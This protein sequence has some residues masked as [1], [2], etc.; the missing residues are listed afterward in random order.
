MLFN[1][2]S[3][4]KRRLRWPTTAFLIHLNRCRSVN[5]VCLKYLHVGN[6]LSLL[7][8]W[9][10]N[11]INAYLHNTCFSLWTHNIAEDRGSRE[12]C[13]GAS[14]S[15]LFWLKKVLH[16]EFYI[17]YSVFGREY[18]SEINIWACRLEW[19]NVG[20]WKQRLCIHSTYLEQRAKHLSHSDVMN[21]LIS[22][23]VLLSLMISGK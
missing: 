1:S 8:D 9:F 17:K 2:S 6:C 14:V 21:K 19:H 16:K 15:I 20:S 4:S 13:R 12:K 23:L 22:Y 3:W 5:I 11:Y 7:N 18:K 10:L